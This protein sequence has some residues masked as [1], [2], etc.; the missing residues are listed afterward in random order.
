MPQSDEAS[1]YVSS[2]RISTLE[3]LGLLTLFSPLGFRP[4]TGFLY[5]FSPIVQS[6]FVFKLR[7]INGVLHI[8]VVCSFHQSKLILLL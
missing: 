5:P 8:V 4:L 3:N 6:N 1:W 7:S 2:I